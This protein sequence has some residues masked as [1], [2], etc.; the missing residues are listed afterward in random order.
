[1]RLKSNSTATTKSIFEWNTNMDTF[2][3]LC[4][5]LT[6]NHTIFQQF[7]ESRI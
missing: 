6:G 1:M 3:Y 2:P 4:M 7:Y 5:Y